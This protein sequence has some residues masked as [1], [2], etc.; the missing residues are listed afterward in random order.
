MNTLLASF[1]TLALTKRCFLFWQTHAGMANH[2]FYILSFTILR[3]SSV[4]YAIVQRSEFTYYSSACGSETDLDPGS[5][6][7][8][9]GTFICK[10]IMF[11]FAAGL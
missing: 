3:L 8:N 1:S 6:A 4:I 7:N 11:W 10:Q 5:N 9:E 2:T